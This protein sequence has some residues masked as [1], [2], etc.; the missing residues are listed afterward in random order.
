MDVKTSLSNY[1]K[2]AGVGIDKEKI[3]KFIQL[4][5]E[6][7][8]HEFRMTVVPGLVDE[9]AIKKVGGLVKGGRR[10]YVQQFEPK[11]TLNP[12]YTKKEPFPKEKLKKF[13]I[14]LS[15]YVNQCKIRKV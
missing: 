3:R 8:E 11:N 14:F 2:A 7:K 4:I 10:F 9:E 5:E 6:I 12:E 15:G 1:S 13:K